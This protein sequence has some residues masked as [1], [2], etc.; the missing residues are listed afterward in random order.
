MTKSLNHVFSQFGNI[1]TIIVSNN[2]RLKGQAWV[3]FENISDAS[4]ALKEM[5]GF[6]FYG[7]EMNVTYARQK[8]DFVKKE[9][10]TYKPYDKRKADAQAG[11]NS[12]RYVAMDEGVDGGM[13]GSANFLR[14]LL[15][16]L[17]LCGPV[18][19]GLY[20]C[21]F[22]RSVACLLVLT[23]DVCVYVC[24]LSSFVLAGPLV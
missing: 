11:E 2:F 17:L 22:V 21:L 20:H 23:E 5:G 12:K 6:S 3:I 15:L 14:V 16:L 10:G 4:K 18:V 8:S 13:E 19:C 9:E 1:R 7:K 24:F